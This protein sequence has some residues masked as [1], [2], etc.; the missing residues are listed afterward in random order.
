MYTV[1]LALKIFF[2]L[3]L[4]IIR[5]EVLGLRAMPYDNFLKFYFSGADFKRKMQKQTTLTIVED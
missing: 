4:K 2:L 3:L 5:S 1:M